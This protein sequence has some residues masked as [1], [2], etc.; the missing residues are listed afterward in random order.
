MTAT[1]SPKSVLARRRGPKPPAAPAAR[2]SPGS[3]G[4]AR[5]RNPLWLAGGLMLVV[6]CGLGGVLL[7]TSADHRSKVVVAAA[8]IAPGSPITRADM[9]IVDMA[10]ADGVASVSP[11]GASELVGLLAVG[12]V[13][14]GT[15]LNTAMFAA[16]VPLGADEM[17]VGAALDPGAAPLSQLQV[18]AEVELLYTPQ[19]TAGTAAEEVADDVAGTAGPPPAVSLGRGVVWSSESLASGQVWVAVRV[20]LAVGRAASQ[21]AHDDALRIALVGASR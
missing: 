17:V 14:E 7:F 10:I 2:F 1:Q 15:L 21:A 6:L 9:R 3:V 8:D 18:G 4:A 11:S 20:P 12:R 13:P 16:A 19:A 5:H